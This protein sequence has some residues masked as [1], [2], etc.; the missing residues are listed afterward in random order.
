MST[1]AAAIPRT[2]STFFFGLLEHR[3]E[4][5]RPSDPGGDEDIPDEREI[6]SGHENDR[7]DPSELPRDFCEPA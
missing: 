5:P 1:R 7:A 6:D 3:S 2:P 4:R